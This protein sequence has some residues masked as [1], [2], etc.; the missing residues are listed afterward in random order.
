MKYLL[1]FFS[2]I[3]YAQSQKF[4]PL[5]NET[6]EFIGEAKYTLYAN[7][8]LVFSSIT[9]KDS[10]TRLPIDVV[11]D[12]IAFTKSNYKETGLKKEDLKEVVLLTKT[13]FELDEVIIPNAK[14]KEIVIGEE[15]RFVAKRS[16]C[17][18]NTPDYGL[19]F[20]KDDLKNMEIKKLNFFVDKVTYKTTYK[21]KFYA[22]SEIGNLIIRQHLELNE[23]LFESPVL[24]LEKGAKNKIEINLEDYDINITNK[25][26]FVCLELQEYYDENNTPFQPEIKDKTKLKFQLSNKINY[27]AKMY[28]VSS[29][30]PSKFMNNINVMINYDFAHQFFK[31]P[32][33]STLVAPTIILYAV[34]IK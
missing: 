29:G 12:S 13:A 15:S 25:D 6:L 10:I 17:L 22:A 20:R 24:T 2:I 34:K 28:D 14:P 8:K 18:S 26:V 11:F 23:L 19:L 1:L 31:K 9:S 33:K 4:I 5:D 16:G 32:H 21:I 30:I 7:K 3:T 27:Y